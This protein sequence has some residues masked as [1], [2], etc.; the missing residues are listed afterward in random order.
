MMQF[1]HRYMYVLGLAACVAVLSI[2]SQGLTL[3]LGHVPDYAFYQEFTEKLAHGVIDLSIPGFHGA[4]VL[5]V[6]FYIVTQSSTSHFLFQMIC[7]LLV[8]L[9]GYL[10][11]YGLYK[12]KLHGML[13]ACILTLMPYSVFS[14]ITG[15]TQTSNIL[16]FL[17]AIYGATK[18]ARWTGIVWALAIL[19]KPFAIIALPIV[20]AYRPRNEA[21]LKRNLQIGIG[22][23]L[24]ALYVL[25]QYIQMGGI[26]VGVH[27]GTES[28]VI[29]HGARKIIGNA[30]W[31]LQALFSI[32]NYYYADPA[33]TGHWNLLH[34]TPVLIF[35]GLFALLSPRTYCTNT[36]LHR[37]LVLSAVFGFVLNSV[38]SM[39]NYYM[40]FLN[41]ILICAALPVIQKHMAWLVFV[42]LSLHY[43]WFY[44]YLEFHERAPMQWYAFMPILF[45]DVI[46]VLW[47]M[48]NVKKLFRSVV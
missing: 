35:L 37:A 22:L 20:L 19:T 46:A 25:V 34:T 44:F 27:G 16:L 29:W 7:G 40:Q 45:F 21:F 26:H 15:Y 24:C 36:Q 12:N 4:D 30:A 31:G 28:L 13:L 43:Q 8:P 9:A 42:L 23:M 48:L 39:D 47:C 38:V 10:A 32:H 3:L 33:I 5:G 14:Y 17:L 1:L 2:G 18:H 11:G 6:F 41:L